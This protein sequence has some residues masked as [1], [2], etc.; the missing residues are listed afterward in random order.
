LNGFNI[1]GIITNILCRDNMAKVFQSSVGK[2][3]LRFLG[4]EFLLYSKLYETWKWVWV[5][6]TRTTWK[7]VLPEF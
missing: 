1:S 3:I 4:I 7:Y 6:K 2:F 5:S